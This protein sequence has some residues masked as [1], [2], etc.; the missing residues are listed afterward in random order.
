MFVQ[1]VCCATVKQLSVRTCACDDETYAFI[2]RNPSLRQTPQDYAPFTLESF[3]MMPNLKSEF[4]S[5]GKYM[6]K[7]PNILTSAWPIQKYRTILFCE[8]GAQNIDQV[9]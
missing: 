1:D 2:N 6:D 4:K 5:N 3:Y 9:V 8:S 7:W